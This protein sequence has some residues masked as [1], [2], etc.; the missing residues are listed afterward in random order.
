MLPK[1]IYTKNK[2]KFKTVI[3]ILEIYLIFLVFS[4]KHT[5]ELLILLSEINQLLI[6]ES[7]TIFKQ[8][9]SR[10]FFY[11]RVTFTVFIFCRNTDQ[12]M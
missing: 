11:N 12:S 10:T 2:L 9:I 7:L 5:K 6:E 3:R 4:Q 1:S 8:F